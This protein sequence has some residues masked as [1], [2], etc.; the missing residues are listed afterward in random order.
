MLHLPKHYNIGSLGF[1]RVKVLNSPTCWG[2]GAKN[3]NKFGTPM[4]HPCK[5]P[6]THNIDC[7]TYKV[8]HLIL[9]YLLNNSTL[10]IFR[11]IVNFCPFCSSQMPYI[12]V[13]SQLSYC[14]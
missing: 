14:I 3:P 8:R 5:L 1:R 9:R 13:L 6:E 10:A 4:R 12:V 11:I 2:C 7:S